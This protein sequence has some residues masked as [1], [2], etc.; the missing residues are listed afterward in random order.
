M[1]KQIWLPV[2][3]NN[4]GSVA[5]VRPYRLWGRVG[6]SQDN[7]TGGGGMP[8]FLVSQVNNMAAGSSYARFSIR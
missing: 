6:E 7:P 2:D 1:G 5:S 4:F 8:S 3:P